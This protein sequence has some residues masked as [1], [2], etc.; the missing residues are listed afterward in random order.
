[1][2]AMGYLETMVD[3]T[4]PPM[5]RSKSPGILSMR[6]MIRKSVAEGEVAENGRTSEMSW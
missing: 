1:M 3:I 6:A 4:Y 5:Y 2:A